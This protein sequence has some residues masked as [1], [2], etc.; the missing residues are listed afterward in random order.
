MIFAIIPI[1]QIAMPS[2]ALF[3]LRIQYE[4]TQTQCDEGTRD[5]I[6]IWYMAHI[7]WGLYHFFTSVK[8]SFSN[9]FKIY[10]LHMKKWW[11]QKKKFWIENLTL[12]EIN[13]K[14]SK[15]MLRWVF[16]RI[17]TSHWSTNRYR[18]EAIWKPFSGYKISLQPASHYQGDN[19]TPRDKKKLARSNNDVIMTSQ[20]HHNDVT[21]STRI[22]LMGI[23]FIIY[24]SLFWSNKLELQL[25]YLTQNLWH[26]NES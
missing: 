26:H 19:F 7:I 23:I 1:Y 5:G 8:L 20:W 2:L 21:N 12:W 6:D 9:V 25:I 22:E 18:I 16:S 3:T 15:I 24:M 14:L 11:D 10:H 4:S 13:L 17:S